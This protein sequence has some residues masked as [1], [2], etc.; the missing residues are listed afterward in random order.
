MMRRNIPFTS[1]V[2]VG[3]ALLVLLGHIAA[4]VN[5]VEM[6]ELAA[7]RAEQAK[8]EFPFGNKPMIVL[9]RGILEEHGPEGKAME[10]ERQRNHAAIAKRSRQGKLIV[11]TRSGHHIQMDEPELVIQSIRDVV[12]AA[13]GKKR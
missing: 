4:G 2:L 3:A 7:L 6:E 10:E 5:P 9:T 12:D 1:P 13:A 8:S 11:A